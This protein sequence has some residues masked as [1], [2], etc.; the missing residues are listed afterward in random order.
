MA[1]TA[2]T[3][4]RLAAAAL[5]AAMICVVT[6]YVFHVPICLN[7]RYIHFGD[8]FVFLAAAML[9]RHY[10]LAAAVVG[11]CLA[12]LLTAPVWIV[13]TLIVKILIVLP[14]SSKEEKLL[15]RRNLLASLLSAP[16]SCVIYYLA[17]ALMF[18]NWL[19]PALDIPMGLIQ[20]LG[21][22]AAFILAALALDRA[23]IKRRVGC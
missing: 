2:K 6:A 20:Y 13:P 8:V 10:A 1:N 23:H 12:D 4:K 16:V 17:E 9:P 7:G 19:A 15:T 21:C 11:S 22:P 18:G 14:F 5:F 3:L